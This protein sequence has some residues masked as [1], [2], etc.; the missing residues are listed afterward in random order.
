MDFD[1]PELDWK[2]ENLLGIAPTDTPYLM[3][4]QPELERC[5]RA[6][7][8]SDVFCFPNDPGAYFLCSRWIIL[9]DKLANFLQIGNSG[10]GPNQGCHYFLSVGAYP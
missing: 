4:T 3:V 6:G 5:G 9:R 2:E 10:L 8:G 7:K 1:C